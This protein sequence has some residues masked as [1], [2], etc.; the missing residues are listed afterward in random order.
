MFDKQKIVDAGL[1]MTERNGD[2][3]EILLYAP[4]NAMLRVGLAFYASQNLK[5]MDQKE[6]DEYHEFREMLERHL[7]AGELK[8]LT[9]SFSRMGVE[10]ARDHYAEL[11][12]KKPQEEQDQGVKEYEEIAKKMT[13]TANASHE[14]PESGSGENANA[15]GSEDGSDGGEKEAGQGDGEAA[16]D[17]MPQAGSDDASPLF[18]S[19]DDGEMVEFDFQAQEG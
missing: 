5:T 15:E 12:A 7:S 2:W 11:F 14:G 13:E 18:G 8:Y 1:A 17:S 16:Q 9:E 6:K 10:K 19:G 4:G 3:R